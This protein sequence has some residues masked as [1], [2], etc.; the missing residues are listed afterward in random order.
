MR[1]SGLEVVLGQN[2]YSCVIGRCVVFNCIDEDSAC[3][4]YP[5]L[6]TPTWPSQQP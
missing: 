4:Y 5:I 1:D 3:V 6:L 2:D